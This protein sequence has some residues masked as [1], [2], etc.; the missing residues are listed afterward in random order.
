MGKWWKQRSA[1]TLALTV[2]MAGMTAAAMTRPRQPLDFRPGHRVLLDAHNAYPQ[3]GRWDD[4]IDRA[5]STGEP[6]AIEQDLYWRRDALT[7][8][9]AIVV[10]HDSDA[11]AIAPTLE[12]HFFEKIRTPMERA[13]RENRRNAWPLI[14]LNLDFK[15]NERA[16]HEAVWAL[17]GKH[18]P[19]L[20]TA[21][22]TLTPASPA[23]LTVGPLLVLV[24]ADKSQRVRFHDMV[25]IGQR[26][27][28][29]GG[30][31]VP[32]PRGATRDARASALASGRASVLIKQRG[33]NYERWVN[34]PWGAVE[35]GGP[36]K[37]DAWTAND[38]LRLHALVSRAHAQGL[39]LRY[40]TL[41]GF[42]ADSDRGYTAAYNFGS[43]AAAERRWRAAILA[44]VDFVATDQYE[45]F[46]RVRASLQRD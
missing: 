41:D 34:L 7:G 8:T 14:V 13:L 40:Y 46:G 42:T 27:L 44:G 23:E 4:R 11:I 43:T 25:P 6:L 38:S 3:S 12:S 35:V 36:T 31:T 10:A 16:L 26:L 39:W 45:E 5:L 20:T 21:P 2:A 17:L 1:V 30:I 29:F 37:A 15:T 32:S 19:W 28:V 33:G 18:E 22:R 24:G 9:H